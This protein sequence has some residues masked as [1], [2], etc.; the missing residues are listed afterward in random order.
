MCAKAARPKQA[1]PKTNAIKLVSTARQTG[2]NQLFQALLQARPSLDQSS[3][4]LKEAFE[5]SDDQ[6]FGN[7]EVNIHLPTDPKKKPKIEAL[8]KGIKIKYVHS[9]DKF[10]GCPESVADRIIRPAIAYMLN[11][12]A[13]PAYIK[14]S[15]YGPGFIKLMLPLI[16]SVYPSLLVSV[17]PMAA[18]TGLIHYIKFRYKKNKKG[19]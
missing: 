1:G 17:Q 7:L 13:L 9:K 2:K 14:V 19:K 16:R 18:S 10:R 8:F 5:V 6:D 3:D 11:G 12:V 4:R 15:T